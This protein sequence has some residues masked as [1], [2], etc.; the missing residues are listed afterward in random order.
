MNPQVQ[1]VLSE[2]EPTMT[3]DK[4]ADPIWQLKCYRVAR[5]LVDQ[6]ADETPSSSCPVY[7]TVP[8]T[9]DF[10]LPETCAPET[11]KANL[12]RFA[13]GV[14]ER[15]GAQPTGLYPNRNRNAMSVQQAMISGPVNSARK[16]LWSYLRCM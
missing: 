16:I 12:A 8:V 7:S 4:T 2:W 11:P 13:F 14:S 3:A 9:C 5:C 1:Q 10:T 15:G 6:T